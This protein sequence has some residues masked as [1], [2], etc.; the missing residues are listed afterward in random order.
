M[1]KDKKTKG[2][3]RAAKDNGGELSTWD[4]VRLVSGFVLM[5]VGAFIFCSIL[6]YLFFWKQDMSALLEVGRP[7]ST[8]EFRNICGEGGANVANMLVGDGFGLFAIIIPIVITIIGWRL[9]R[10]KPLRLHRFGHH[11]AAGLRQGHETNAGQPRGS[12]HA[13]KLNARGPS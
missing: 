8:P 11:A 12:G 7:M 4:N 1:A 6:S 2:R 3:T 5:L 9:F 10:Y 13:G